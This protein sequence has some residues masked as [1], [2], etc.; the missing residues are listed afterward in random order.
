MAWYF[1]Q[2]GLAVLLPRSAVKSLCWFDVTPI[3]VTGLWGFLVVYLQN[4]N[5]RLFGKNCSRFPKL[6]FNSYALFYCNA[7]FKE[8]YIW[9]I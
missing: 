9:E 8:L 3:F 2:P 1:D 7:L 6:L 5:Y 4:N